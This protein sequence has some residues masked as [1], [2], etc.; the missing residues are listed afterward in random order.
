MSHLVDQIGCFL[1]Q[2]RHFR[3]LRLPVNVIHDALGRLYGHK[4]ANWSNREIDTLKL[5]F[6]C[7]FNTARI[8]SQK[9]VDLPLVWCVALFLNTNLLLGW[10]AL[11]QILQ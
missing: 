8:L 6:D 11:S 10:N 3:L 7:D 9:L 2:A 5:A 1:H 4:F